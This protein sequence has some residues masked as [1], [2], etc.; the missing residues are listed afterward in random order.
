MTKNQMHKWTQLRRLKSK[1][2]KANLARKS[3]RAPSTAP[4][5]SL[6]RQVTEESGFY[7]SALAYLEVVGG[8]VGFSG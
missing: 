7:K 4:P 5:P 3:L 6:R 8:G 2:A 1:G